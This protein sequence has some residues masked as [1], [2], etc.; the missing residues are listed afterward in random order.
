VGRYNLLMDEPERFAAFVARV[1]SR[2]RGPWFA[3]AYLVVLPPLVM[4]YVLMRLCENLRL[5]LV[6]LLRGAWIRR[7]AVEE[8]HR[9]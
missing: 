8:R 2:F 5:M 9:P 7:S 3:F 4:A 1:I 6:R